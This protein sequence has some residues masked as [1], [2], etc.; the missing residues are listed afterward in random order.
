M[1]ITLISDTHGL[2]EELK[3]SAGQILIHA[4]DIT[5]YGTEEEVIDF[6]KWFAQ[7]PYNYK[8][9]IAGNHDFF[10]QECKPSK[11]KRLIPE[12]IIYLQNSGI[13]INGINIWGSPV[14]P[15]FLG[16]AFNARSGKPLKKVWDKIPTN[17]DILI[18]HG[19]PEGI[20]DNGFGC[21]QLMEQVNK[22]QPLIHVFG[23][24]H[25]QHGTQQLGN[26]K[27][28]NAALVN[29]LNQMESKGYRIFGKPICT[30]L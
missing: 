12:N 2:H 30:I 13:Q 21:N 9:F 7:Q 23:H 18:T 10:L 22:T 27:F 16:M 25:Q 3:L 6:L 20:L 19:P 8:I 28:I 29:T 17:T 11:L 1:N 26:T 5:E 4:G 14:I 24:I 15:Y